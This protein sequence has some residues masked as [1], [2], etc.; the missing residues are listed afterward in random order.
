MINFFCTN[1]VR[2]YKLSNDQKVRLSNYHICYVRGRCKC[3]LCN[4]C[5]PFGFRAAK[6]YH[7]SGCSAHIE[8]LPA[9]SR[10]YFF[11][12]LRHVLPMG[13]EFAMDGDVDGLDL[14]QFI[15]NEYNQALYLEEFINEFG[16]VD[17]F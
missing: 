14:F 9:L 3:N 15:Y 7:G 4:I 1:I 10:V 12:D 6:P 8:K 17:C 2:T 13:F 11:L 5:V 16:R